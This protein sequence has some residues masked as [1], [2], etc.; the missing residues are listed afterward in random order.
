MRYFSAALLPRVCLGRPNYIGEREFY[1]CCCC[2]CCLVRSAL[3]G[4]EKRA[5]AQKKK[6]T[7]LQDFSALGYR[8][9][10]PTARI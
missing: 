5:G 9:G 4:E 7:L 3:G 6:K 10:L 2:Y 8:P 1:Y